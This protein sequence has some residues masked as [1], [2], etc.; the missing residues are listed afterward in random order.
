MSPW[1][2]RTIQFC[3][4]PPC[5]DGVLTAIN[6]TLEASVL[7]QEVPSLLLKGIEEVPSSDVNHS[8]FSH[9][10]LDLK[11]DGGLRPILDL[12]R[13]NFSLYKGTFKMLTLKTQ[14]RVEDWILK[15]AYF[16]IQVVQRIH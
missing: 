14:V 10:L 7:L 9:Y 4:N 15:D 8:F 2:L 12:R 11:K 1:I 6:S 3:H 13:L 5:F 16:H